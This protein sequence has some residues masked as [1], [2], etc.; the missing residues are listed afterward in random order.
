MISPEV[1]AWSDIGRQRDLNEDRLFYQVLQSSD[2]DPVALCMVADGMGGHLAGEVASHWVIE[3]L[4]RELA[5]LFVPL[6]PRQT[7]Q[8]RGADLRAL[9]QEKDKN[10]SPS[11]IVLKRR[12]RK[13]VERANMAVHEYTL[14]RPQE[15]MGAGSTLTM[16]LVKG[17]RAFI[18][19]IGDSRT[20]LLRQGHLRQLTR[21]HSV[22]AELVAAGH[23]KPE[24][25]YDHP[26][27]GLLTRCMGCLNQVEVEIGICTLESGDCLLLC[28]D[29]LWSMLRDPKM[30]SRIIEISP[31]LET[32]THR[33][34]EAANHAGGQDN[35]SVA[36]VRVMEKK[37]IPT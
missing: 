33:L 13:A 28:C 5:D 26:Q 7:L 10:L 18:A 1:A 32:A 35:I 22:V 11:D 37:N 34:V 17:M 31:D 12:L 9:A 21:D 16:A 24:D 4:K 2:A 27:A 14:H 6:D 19:N 15:A 29:G 25:A 30:I 20:Y 8:L 36:L 23:V 3:T